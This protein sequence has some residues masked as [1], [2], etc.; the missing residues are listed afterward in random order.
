MIFQNSFLNIYRSHDPDGAGLTACPFLLPLT[1]DSGQE[2]LYN[3]LNH[4]IIL[5]YIR[6]KEM[7]KACYQCNGSGKVHRS[8]MPHD[9][10]CI[11]C[12]PCWGCGASGII[13]DNASECPKCQ[14]SG[15]IHNSTMPHS[16]DCIFCISCSRCSGKGWV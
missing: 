2:Y 13:P 10:G 9:P 3:I 6:K 7:A 4:K 12:K 15:R 16:P 1:R 14:G 5:T 8:S 11:F